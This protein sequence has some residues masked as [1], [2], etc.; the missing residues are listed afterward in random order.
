M[1]SSDRRPL[2]LFYFARLRRHAAAMTGMFVCM[3]MAAFL[4]PLLALM[5]KPILDGSGGDFAVAPEQIPAAMAAVLLLLAAATYGRVYLGGW[6][7]STMQRDLRSEMAA[8]LVRRPLESTRRESPGK[9]TS[10]FMAYVPSLTGPTMPVFTALVQ[11]PLKTMFYLAQMMYLQWELALIVCAA[12]PPTAM[13]I[14][15]LTRRMK[16]VATRAQNEVARSQSRL[17]ESIAL[18]PVIKIQG[19]RSAAHHLHRAFSQLRSASIRVLIVVAAGR[20]LS[21]LIIAVPS[22]IVVSYVVRAL[23]AETMSP[24]DVAAFLGCMLLLPRS[25]RVITRAATHLESMLAA[26]RE[27]VGFLREEEEEDV[28]KK[29]ASRAAGKIELRN[30]GLRYPGAPRPA[31][32]DVSLTLAAGETVALVG[33]SGAGKTTL[34]NLL[35]RFYSP[36]KGEVLL[37][38][39]DIRELTL[40]SLR[41]QI[42]VVTQEPLLFDDTAA[43][44]VCYPERPSEKNRDKIWRAMQDAAADDFISALPEG[45]DAQVGENGRQLSGGQCQRLALARAFYRDAPIVILDEATSSLDAEAEGKIKLAMRKLLSG[46]TALIIAHRFA[47]VDFADRVLV[48]DEGRLIAQG[49]SQTLLQTCPLYAALYR[50]QKLS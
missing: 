19:A 13:L 34:A 42:A 40:E 41:A 6:L 28:G 24:G 12:L 21:M 7:N 8:Q 16:K 9:T 1:S 18:M 27:V 46:R 22:V 37:D 14:R 36:E 35:P 29:V 26:A 2:I 3:A 33:K 25:V 10:R 39:T 11:E 23:E 20:P 48:L 4:E 47:S 43:A 50:A 32:S 44:N 5:L 15:T 17:N 30:V 49:D 31:L 38:G 45:M